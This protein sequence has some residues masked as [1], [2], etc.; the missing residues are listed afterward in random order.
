[1]KLNKFKL[2]NGLKTA[3][4]IILSVAAVGGVIWTAIQS[5]LDRDRYSERKIKAMEAKLKD[6]QTDIKLT[7]KEEAKLIAQTYLPTAAAVVT[8]SSCIIAS[9]VI[10]KKQ[11]VAMATIAA[12]GMKAYD[13]IYDVCY[14]TEVDKDGNVVHKASEPYDVTLE[15]GQELFWEPHYGYFVAARADVLQGILELNKCLDA[16]SGATIND[17]LRI[18]LRGDKNIDK[19]TFDALGNVGWSAD[20]LWDEGETNKI[21]AD[22]PEPGAPLEPEDDGPH[23]LRCYDIEWEVPPMINPWE[24]DPFA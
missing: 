22:I 6:G 12:A 10:S 14:N 19:D 1:M 23:I 7:K 9:T 2:I 8:T 24:Y 5:S 4:P 3:S 20:Y 16:N 15:D 18:A 17:F 11:T 21:F 13:T